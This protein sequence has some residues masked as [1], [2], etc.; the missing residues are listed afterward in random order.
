MT[1]SPRKIQ[2]FIVAM[3]PKKG[4]TSHRSS[5]L[6]ANCPEENSDRRSVRLAG[7]NLLRR[8]SCSS[9]NGSFPR[10]SCQSPVSQRISPVAIVANCHFLAGTTF[11]YSLGKAANGGEQRVIPGTFQEGLN[12]SR[13]PGSTQENRTRTN[14]G[15]ANASLPLGTLMESFSRS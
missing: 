13:I 7:M 5:P 14:K 4:K 6:Q 11:A 10:I 15:E 12:P 9:K 8:R 1:I 3:I 2:T